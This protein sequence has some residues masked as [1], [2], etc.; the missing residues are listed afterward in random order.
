M[1]LHPFCLEVR[2]GSMAGARFERQAPTVEI[3]RSDPTHGLVPDIDLSGAEAP[4]VMRLSRR[5]ARLLRDADGWRL[6]DLGSRNGTFVN[7]RRL[8]PRDFRGVLLSTGDEIRFGEV[9]VRF[10]ALS[11]AQPL[12]A[13]LQEPPSVASVMVFPPRRAQHFRIW[14]AAGLVA[15]SLGFL[16]VLPG[17]RDRAAGLADGLAG[18]WT[19]RAC[20]VL[21]S[22]CQQAAAARLEAETRQYDDLALRLAQAQGA[23]ASTLAETRAEWGRVAG[24][25]QKLQEAKDAGHF[26]TTV[27]D[28]RLETRAEAE[29]RLSEMARH[30]AQAEARRSRLETVAADLDRRRVAVLK[31]SEEARTQRA[32][33]PADAALRQTGH[34]LPSLAEVPVD[35]ED[36]GRSERDVA[37]SLL[38]STDELLGR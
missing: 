25:A 15:A 19:A 22:S 33:L 23:L 13:P 1:A 16:A 38:R 12:A 29:A 32:L 34:L 7:G 3:G 36:R 18:R 10:D 26:P 37:E 2:S 4:G 5:H 6:H 17:V 9:E 30:S 24:E 21:P 28:W 14:W 31:L 8:D 35:A 20:A 11:P 27:G